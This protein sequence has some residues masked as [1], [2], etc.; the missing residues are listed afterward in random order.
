M[1]PKRVKLDE[2]QERLVLDVYDQS[3]E[4]HK[5]YWERLHPWRLAVLE[6]ATLASHLDRKDMEKGEWPPGS[7]VVPRE[8]AARFTRDVLDCVVDCEK[9]ALRV[10]QALK[11][12]G[13]WAGAPSASSNKPCPAPAHPELLVAVFATL[14]GLKL[15][16]VQEVID[17]KRKPD[18]R[19]AGILAKLLRRVTGGKTLQKLVAR[20]A[21]IDAAELAKA[22]AEK[23]T[24]G[25]L[26]PGEELELVAGDV[27]LVHQPYL[28]LALAKQLGRTEDEVQLAID[29]ARS[30]KGK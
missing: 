17:N 5:W 20:Q 23:R 21:R 1:P 27:P 11:P 10:E 3:V 13:A 14:L 18:A 7:E 16:A 15:E 30:R 29:I 19:Q 28:V 22:L 6:V 9:L 4:I 2:E 26:E 8:Q 25:E 12:F 24:S